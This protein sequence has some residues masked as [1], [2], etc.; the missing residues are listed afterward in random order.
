MAVKNSESDTHVVVSSRA[1]SDAGSTPAASTILFSFRIFEFK[2]EISDGSTNL[3][4]QQKVWGQRACSQGENCWFDPQ[5]DGPPAHDPQT[6]QTSSQ[7]GGASAPT[8]GTLIGY[9]QYN[10]VTNLYE[11][12]SELRRRLEHLRES[13]DAGLYALYGDSIQ[14]GQR[15][16]S[17]GSQSG[18]FTYFENSL[19]RDESVRPGRVVVAQGTAALESRTSYAFV[20]PTHLTIRQDQASTGDGAIRTDIPYDGLGRMVESDQYESASVYIATTTTY[21]ALGRTRTTTNPSG[22]ETA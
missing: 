9:D 8:S 4:T 21:D 20:S 1:I 18:Q 3:L 7:L 11:F 13:R 12:D 10:N 6:C 16:C 17:G 19:R 14:D 15:L 22:P 5:A 2:A